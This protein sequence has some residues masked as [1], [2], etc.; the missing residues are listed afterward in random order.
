M[1]KYIYIII[2]VLLI[3]LA[4]AVCYIWTQNRSLKKDL[5]SAQGNEKAL[6]ARSDSLNEKARVLQLTA[7]QL[8]CYNGF[9][10]EDLKQVKDS[11]KIKDKS[12]KGL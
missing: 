2:A 8:D 11:L 10:L 3:G 1:R 7:E 4:V 9:L 5:S 6:L 12:L